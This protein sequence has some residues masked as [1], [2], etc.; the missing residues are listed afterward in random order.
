[1]IDI[2]GDG[3]TDYPFYQDLQGREEA[4]FAGFSN[5]R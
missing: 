5:G 3:K 2:K 1:M 4:G